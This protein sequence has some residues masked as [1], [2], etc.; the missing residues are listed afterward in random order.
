MAVRKAIFAGSRTV[1]T[2]LRRALAGSDG[3]GGLP[4]CH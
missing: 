2:P 3:M 1:R 4:G